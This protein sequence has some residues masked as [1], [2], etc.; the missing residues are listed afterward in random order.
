MFGF[1]VLA[2][3]HLTELYKQYYLLFWYTSA[4]ILATL[5]FLREG[6]RPF[7][8]EILI[9]GVMGLSNILGLLSTA[10]TLGC[11]LPGIVVFPVT[12]G[13]NLFLVAAFGVLWYKEKIGKYG[14]AGIT[15]GI[16]GMILLSLP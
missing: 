15:V 2:D 9:G 1:R 10:T 5:I 8:R 14:Y 6:T 13:G 3:H 11:G 16:I 7:R 12:T 4:S